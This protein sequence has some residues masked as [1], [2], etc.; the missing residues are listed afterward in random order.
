MSGPRAGSS[1][2]SP[3]RARLDHSAPGAWAPARRGDGSRSADVAAVRGVLGFRPAASRPKSA[4]AVGLAE[5]LWRQAVQAGG[6]ADQVAVRP[7]A[8]AWALASG[9]VL[10]LGAGGDR[11][12]GL[13]RVRIPRRGSGVGR[14]VARQ[15]PALRSE[16]W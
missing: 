3:R 16:G 7:G 10:T 1:A 2:A 6:A 4:R 15:R 11:G 14:R 12:G 13:E 8:R 9:A 5:G